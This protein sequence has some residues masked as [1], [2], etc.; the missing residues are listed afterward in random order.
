M[1]T[2]S[3]FK[4]LYP[5]YKGD[6]DKFVSA[7]NA[8]M[9]KVGIDTPKRIAAFLSQCAHES[10]GFTTFSENLN[11]SVVGLATTF[12]KYFNNNNASAY[13]RNAQKIANKVY[14][15]RMGN[16]DEA[17]GDGYR[18]RGRGIIQLTGKTNYAAFDAKALANP[19]LVATDMVTAIK[20]AVWFWNKN[21]LNVL[22]DKS[23]IIGITKRINGGVNGLDDRVSLYNKAIKLL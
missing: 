8:E 20:A 3:T 12:P 23:D 9:S 15:N 14:A 11:Y 13:A 4:T 22:A 16:G 7:L 5:N 17:S 1:I 21:S 18:Y 19:D 10:A 6:V 2:V